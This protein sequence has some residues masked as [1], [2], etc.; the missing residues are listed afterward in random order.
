[1]PD[2]RALNLPSLSDS[3]LSFFSQLGILSG[4]SPSF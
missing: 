3:V 1:M 2:L 4:T